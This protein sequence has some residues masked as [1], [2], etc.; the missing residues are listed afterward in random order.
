VGVFETIEVDGHGI[1]LVNERDI[2]FDGG[3]VRLPKRSSGPE[4]VFRQ[5]GAIGS[6]KL[7][8]KANRANP[9]SGAPAQHN[10]TLRIGTDR[11]PDVAPL[12]NVFTLSWDPRSYNR[13]STGGRASSNTGGSGQVISQAPNITPAGGI[14]WDPAK[15]CGGG[16]GTTG[17]VVRDPVGRISP[18]LWCGKRL[19]DCIRDVYVNGKEPEI[20]LPDDR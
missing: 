4:N 14:T 11:I 16:G 8:L 15:T 7:E 9:E 3:S 1:D 13:R 5:G 10:F 19:S 6:V 18:P 20:T 12:P 2:T 17:F